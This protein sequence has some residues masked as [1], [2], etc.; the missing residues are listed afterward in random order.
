MDAKQLRALVRT[1]LSHFRNEEPVTEKVIYNRRTDTE[2]VVVKYAYK[3]EVS[4]PFMHGRGEY[5]AA[6][7]LVS[8]GF[9]PEQLQLLADNLTIDLSEIG[10]GIFFIPL[11][12][13]ERGASLYVNEEEVYSNYY[14]G[15]ASRALMLAFGIDD[16][17]ELVGD[18]QPLA[19]ISLRFPAWVLDEE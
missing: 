5:K 10:I 8:G 2:R 7:I 12:S 6:N 16:H 1:S 11:E 18:G 17:D 19:Y 13:E 15:K 14:N 4:L 9:T 3:G